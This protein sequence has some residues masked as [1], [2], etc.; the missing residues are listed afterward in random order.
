MD[1]HDSRFDGI[2]HQIASAVRVAARSATDAWCSSVLLPPALFVDEIV[3]TLKVASGMRRVTMPGELV[4]I[5]LNL[6]GNIPAP[7]DIRRPLRLEI[8]PF[9]IGVGYVRMEDTPEGFVLLRM[10]LG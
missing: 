1:G 4:R 8:L 5:D 7:L 9:I 6:S 10:D 2:L 3:Q